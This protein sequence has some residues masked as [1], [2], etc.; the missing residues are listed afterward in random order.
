MKH[1]RAVS[2]HF[3]GAALYLTSGHTKGVEHKQLF[4][5]PLTPSVMCLFTT[6]NYLQPIL[7]ALQHIVIAYHLAGQ[8][9]HIDK[10]KW[11]FPY[12]MALL[13][14]MQ[15]GNVGTQVLVERQPPR[16]NSWVAASEQIYR[17]PNVL[18]RYIMSTT[19]S[20]I[21]NLINVSFPRVLIVLWCYKFSLYSSKLIPFDTTSQ[22]GVKA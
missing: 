11:H 12:Q 17:N 1:F 13:C 7:Y 10:P 6:G 15:F 9:A 18:N 5:K 21:I 8:S 20:D 3:P 19:I 4:S 22:G 14:D 2:L 16:G